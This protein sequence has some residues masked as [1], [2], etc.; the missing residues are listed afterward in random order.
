MVRKKSRFP[1]IKR[2]LGVLL[3]LAM[4]LGMG[5]LPPT[6]AHMTAQT[7]AVQALPNAQNLVEQGR[8]LYE[9]ERFAEAAAIWQQA[10]SAFQAHGD[11]LRLAMT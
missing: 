8:K 10:I 3:L 7:S 5:L 2:L 6:F 9:A 1:R 11:E 4:F